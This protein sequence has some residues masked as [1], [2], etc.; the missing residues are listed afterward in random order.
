MNNY[1]GNLS[2]S[3]KFEKLETMND[4][5]NYYNE[6]AHMSNYS[7]ILLVDKNTSKRIWAMY[8]YFQPLDFSAIIIPKKRTVYS[9]KTIAKMTTLRRG[10]MK[11]ILPYKNCKDRVIN[12]NNILK[13]LAPTIYVLWN[14]ETW[15]FNWD[16][17]GSH[18]QDKNIT[19]RNITDD[20]DVYC[21]IN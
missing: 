14:G 9:L 7:L 13:S 20:Y 10:P 19:D 15:E 16:K 2:A 6:S 5:Y 3:I 11:I 1:V 21:T 18:T 8:Y 17:L 4:I 12:E